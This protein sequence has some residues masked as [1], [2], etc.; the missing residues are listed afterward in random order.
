MFPFSLPNDQQAGADVQEAPP[1]HEKNFPVQV[2]KLW[3]S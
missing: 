1:E 3:D 2:T